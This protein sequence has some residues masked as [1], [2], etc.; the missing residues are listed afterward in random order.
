[1]KALTDP[2]PLDPFTEVLGKIQPSLSFAV[3]PG[4]ILMPTNASTFK[5]DSSGKA[6]FGSSTGAA[7]VISPTDGLFHS[8]DGGATKSGKLTLSPTQPWD[9]VT[10]KQIGRAHV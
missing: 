5:I 10:G 7:V 9:I 1:M 4:C 2:D 6:R 8:S 3:L